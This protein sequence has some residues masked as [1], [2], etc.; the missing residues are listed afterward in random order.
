M[1]QVHRGFDIGYQALITSEN[2][3]KNAD[4]LPGYIGSSPALYYANVVKVWKVDR[5]GQDLTQPLH[6]LQREY[7]NY[8]FQDGGFYL[9]TVNP[10]EVGV[11]Y[12][13]PVAL[14]VV[15]P[16]TR[17]IDP[18]NQSL[19][20]LFWSLDKNTRWKISPVSQEETYLYEPI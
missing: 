7:R 9:S 6:W 18:K 14:Q 4:L 16:E 12:R 2:T 17:Q 13:R 20:Y 10:V 19:F 11:N 5:Y 8:L 1:S 15:D 3:I